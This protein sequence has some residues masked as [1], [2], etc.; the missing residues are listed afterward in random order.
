MWEPQTDRQSLIMVANYAAFYSGNFIASLTALEERLKIYNVAVSYVFPQ[1]A[2]FS[3]WGEDGK[4]AEQH[5]VHAVDFAPKSLAATLKKMVKDRSTIVHMHFLDWKTLW[6]VKDA[7]KEKHCSMIFQEHMRVNFVEEQVRRGLPGM[8]KAYLKKLLY[9]H[10]TSGYWVIGVSDAVYDDI[11]RS[12]GKKTMYMVRNAI[13]T[14]RL[15]GQKNN[16]LSLD[17]ARDVVIFGTHFERKGVDIALQ[18]VKEAE[19]NLRLVVLT[20]HEDDAME[21]LNAV[22]AEW[23]N[24]AVVKHVVEDISGVYN[25]ALCF[26]SPSRSEAFGYAVVEAAYCN[27]QVIASD[28]PGQNSMK[29]IPGIQWI[30]SENVDDLK[31]ALIRCYEMQRDKVE[32]LRIQNRAQRAYICEHF[33][34]E[35]WC[36][37]IMKVYGIGE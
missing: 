7:L 18:A 25:H 15:D 26:I 2:P 9:R 37:D 28:V 11:C 32:D 10:A 35:K 36:L 34:V 13:A 21:R 30:Q 14:N 20:H 29:C 24:F 27:T 4:F 1:S 22:D 33:G 23:N 19:N 31:N 8:A 6:I 12:R 5:E 16:D 17:P 3:Y